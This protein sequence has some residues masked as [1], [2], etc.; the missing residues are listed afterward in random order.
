MSNKDILCRL[1]LK[2]ELNLKYLIPLQSNYSSGDKIKLRI[3][4]ATDFYFNK[5]DK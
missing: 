3:Y 4:K 5:I 1:V 2:F